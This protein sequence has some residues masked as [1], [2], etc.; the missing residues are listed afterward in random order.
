MS[1]KKAEQVL[2]VELIELIQQYA[3]GICLY[4]P[5]KENTRRKWGEKTSTLSEIDERNDCIFIDYN[6]GMT[7]TSLAEKYFLSEKSI[8]RILRQKKQY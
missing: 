4:I 5:R 6:N 8:Q 7:V 1:Y 2:P 3:D